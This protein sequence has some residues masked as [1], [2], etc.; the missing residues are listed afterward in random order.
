MPMTADMGF[1]SPLTRGFGSRAALAGADRNSAHSTARQK[2]RR[3]V[4]LRGLMNSDRRLT[5][6]GRVY[7][8]RP[9]SSA[10]VGRQQQ[11]PGARRQRLGQVR[12]E[13][14]AVERQQ[15]LRRQP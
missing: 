13:A 12:H 7:E 5:R 15:V 4:A 9:P 14:L 3:T 8:E 1:F 2:T 11:Q 6:T 10:R